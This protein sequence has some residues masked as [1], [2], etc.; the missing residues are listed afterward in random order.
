MLATGL[1]DVS[2]RLGDLRVPCGVAELIG[3][4]PREGVAGGHDHV[5]GL[6]SL[7]LTL[8]LGV[9]GD[10]KYPARREEVRPVAQLARVELD[11][12]LVPG[13]VSKVLLRERPQGVAAND[14]VLG[15]RRPSLA[16]VELLL[17]RRRA[18]VRSALLDVRGHRGVGRD[19]RT[20]GRS[21]F[22]VHGRRG[23]RGGRGRGNGH[24][25][26]QQ[27]RGPDEATGRVLGQPEPGQP[28]RTNAAQLGDELDDD[29]HDQEGP[30]DPGRE[31]HEQEQQGAVVRRGEHPGEGLERQALE[32][33]AGEGQ[34]HGGQPRGDRDDREGGEQALESTH[35]C[36]TPPTARTTRAW[37]SPVTRMLLIPTIERN[38]VR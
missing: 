35:H 29:A 10:L 7:R 4:D 38:W 17:L 36:S 37:P 25:G 5:L 23:A 24:S 8:G 33:V 11:D 13:A 18:L 30:G 27:Q 32:R 12:L 31:L 1:L 26:E 6:V 19:R 15:E 28:G 16:L 20:D 3:R 9:G 2:G 21:Q 22:G 14:R 34:Q